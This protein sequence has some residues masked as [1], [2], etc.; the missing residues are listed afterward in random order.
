MRN[1]HDAYLQLK[2]EHDEES[3]RSVS[4]GVKLEDALSRAQRAGVCVCVI[5][6]SC[7]C[8]CVCVCLYV[9][10]CVCVCV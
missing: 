8:M 10:V 5:V 4:L 9:C 3:R 1:F 6:W 7:V 2:K